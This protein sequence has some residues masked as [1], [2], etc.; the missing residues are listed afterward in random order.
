MGAKKYQSAVEELF[1]KSPVVD[2]GSVSRIVG[3]AYSRNLLRNLEKRG[4]IYRLTK[5][6]YTKYPEVSLIVY[7]FS[8]A[9][10]GLQDAMSFHGV[11]EQE[12][13][14]VVLTTKIA[15]QGLRQSMGANY[16]VHTIEK[17]YMFGY[18][19]VLVGDFYLPYSDIEKTFIDMVYFDEALDAGAMK[20]F[21]KT[22][23]ERKLR[24]Y[25]LK[26]PQEFQIR[27]AEILKGASS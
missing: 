20:S 24:H 27:V 9:Y 4:T 15:R 7:C 25:L 17:Q 21:V 26:Y 6:Y 10:L 13:N 11:W 2:S 5:G 23:D 18:G 3:S 12:S 22:M 8:P 1:Q 19:L 14:P 16:V